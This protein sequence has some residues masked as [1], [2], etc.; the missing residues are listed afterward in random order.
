MWWTDVQLYI[1][2][3]G[4]QIQIRSAGHVGLMTHNQVVQIVHTDPQ[5]FRTRWIGQL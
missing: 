3:D 4:I 2:Q 5:A 1:V